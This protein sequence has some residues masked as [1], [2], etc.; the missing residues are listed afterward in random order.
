MDELQSAARNAL[1]SVEN[2]QEEIEATEGILS[3]ARERLARGAEDLGSEWARLAGKVSEFATLVGE[4]T[5]GLQAE[6]RGAADSRGQ[7][8]AAYGR[9]QADARQQ[10]AAAERAL[11]DLAERIGDL[12]GGIEGALAEA[13]QVLAGLRDKAGAVGQELEGTLGEVRQ[14][15]EQDLAGEL[16]AFEEELE[17]RTRAAQDAL[18]NEFGAGVE[19]KIDEL[20]QQLHSAQTRLEEAMEAAGTSVAQAAEGAVEESGGLQ[21]QLGSELTQLADALEVVFDRLREFTEDGG[22]A[23]GRQRQAMCDAARDTSGAVTAALAQ[24]QETEEV[25]RRYSFVR[26]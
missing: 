10:R 17:A 19:S 16:A 6:S 18:A 21:E 26:F 24:I 14:L 12:E 25:L 22:D 15:I 7:L 23:L 3:D 2:L 5:K 8:G 11:G 13:E 4:R 9:L 1:E 20:L